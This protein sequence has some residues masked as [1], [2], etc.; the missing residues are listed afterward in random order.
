MFTQFTW[1]IYKPHII[2]FGAQKNG[3]IEMVLF[4]YPQHVLWF[5]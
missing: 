1:K 5:G 3:L 4:E 2:Y